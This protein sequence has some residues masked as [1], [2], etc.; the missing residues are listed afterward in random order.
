MFSPIPFS[1][2]TPPL[3]A[4]VAWCATSFATRVTR[5]MGD[6]F[7][8]ERLRAFFAMPAVAP[9]FA[10]AF[11]VADLVLLFRPD[12]APLA[13][14]RRDVDLADRADADRLELPRFVAP[15]FLDFVAPAFLRDRL[16]R[17]A[18]APS[19]RSRGYVHVR[20]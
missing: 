17:V 14:P 6:C 7:P 19:H 10:D 3:T 12:A 1:A 16:A 9:R 15:R 5:S 13:P 18:M 8:V 20:G 2:S 4:A 11:F